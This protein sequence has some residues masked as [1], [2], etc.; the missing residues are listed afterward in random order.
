MSRI[1]TIALVKGCATSNHAVTPTTYQ[2]VSLTSGEYGPSVTRTADEPDAPFPDATSWTL[3]IDQSAGRLT[4]IGPTGSETHALV[5]IPDA[6]QEVGCRA[7]TTMSR[8]EGFTI[9]APLTVGTIQLARP[10]LAA[11]CPEGNRITLRDAGTNTPEIW[12]ERRLAH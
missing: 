7:G 9:D 1:W 4:I 2:P 11:R 6:Q 12:F 8:E 5:R 10:I 3:R